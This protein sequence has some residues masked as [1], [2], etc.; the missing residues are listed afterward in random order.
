MTRIAV[1]GAGIAGLAAARDLAARG[2]ACTVF[3]KSRGLGGRMATRRAGPLRFDHGAQ[4]FTAR[5]PSLQ[6]RAREWQ[7]LGAAAEWAP[8][9]LVGCPDM[10]APAHALARGLTIHRE[11][12]ITQLIPTADGW[13]LQADPAPSPADLEAAFAAVLLAIPAPQAADLSRPS[14]VELP[15]LD[16]VRYA[17]TITLMAAFD[18]PLSGI[19]EALEPESGPLAW[20][21]RNHTKPGRAARPETV[22]A[23]AGSEWSRA[24]I[25]SDPETLVAPLT[26]ALRPYVGEAEPVHRQVHRWLYARVEQ[27]ADQPCLWDADR[28]LGACG[29]WALGA[30][31]EAAFD[32]GESLAAAVAASLP[33]VPTPHPRGI[34]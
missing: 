32:S 29:D 33:V 6:A 13:R 15:A 25:E 14:G 12:R 28:R 10:T 4:Y 21:A 1:I 16:A 27:A 19:G 8:G 7:T 26:Q 24:H 9:R 2:Y 18:R 20:I 23:H 22:V 5:G 11:C 17:P 3:E 30:R 31:V 34:P